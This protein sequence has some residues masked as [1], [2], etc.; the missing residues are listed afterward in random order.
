M[1]RTGL[2][3]LA[4]GLVALAACQKAEKTEVSPILSDKDKVQ[5]SQKLAALRAP[6][7]LTLYTDGREPRYSPKARQLLGEV[8]QISD[9]VTVTHKDI[10]G[11]AKEAAA[12]GVALA[13]GLLFGTS[14]PSRLR[15]YGVPMGYEFQ[16]MMEAIEI[17]GAGEP[18]LM[19]ETRQF[20]ANLKTP[21]T[22]K[23]MSTPT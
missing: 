22:L 4:I 3:L 13:P 21:V 7:A 12:D 8:D 16:S 23:V 11:D 19:P 20:L 1:R 5:V 14:S 10:A 17:V 18:V 2:F 15:F 9:K 6:V